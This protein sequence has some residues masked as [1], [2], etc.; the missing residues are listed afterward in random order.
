[1]LVFIFLCL[2]YYDLF[3]A[4]VLSLFSE[5]EMISACA[6]DRSVQSVKSSFQSEAVAPSAGI[7][8]EPAPPQVVEV[9][10]RLGASRAQ[11]FDP[12]VQC[13]YCGLCDDDECAMKCFPLDMNHAP[14]ARGWRR[15]GL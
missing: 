4:S 13:R 2:T 6:A 11:I 7:L 1:M 8:S 9:V 15:Y 10:A 5:S 14:T 12:C 3:M